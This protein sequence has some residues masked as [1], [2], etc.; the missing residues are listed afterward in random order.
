[1]RYK[2]AVSRDGNLHIFERLHTSVVITNMVIL[3]TKSIHLGL[4]EKTIFNSVR[5]MYYFVIN[6]R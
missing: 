1:M 4:V 5:F 2:H 3:V 6:G